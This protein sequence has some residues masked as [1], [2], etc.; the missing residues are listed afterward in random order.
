MKSPYPSPS[1]PSR[2]ESDWPEKAARIAA[3][4]HS[5]ILYFTTEV[6]NI[7]CSAAEATTAASEFFAMIVA[8]AISA[9]PPVKRQE[10]LTEA[11]ALISSLIHSH[12]E[13]F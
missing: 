10:A 4:R 13:N 2:D 5:L 11:T 7:G 9:A 8:A 1:A 6:S 3:L 12:M